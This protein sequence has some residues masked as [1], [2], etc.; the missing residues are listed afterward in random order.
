MT[1]QEERTVEAGAAAGDKPLLMETPEVP[2]AG[3][4]YRMRRLSYPD[5]ARLARMLVIGKQ[6]ARLDMLPLLAS[7]NPLTQTEAFTT[8]LMAAFGFAEQDSIAFLA[9]VLGI[10]VGEIRDPDRFPIA[11]LPAVFQ[12]IGDHPDL[13]AF[14]A[15]VQRITTLRKETGSSESATPTSPS[16]GPLIS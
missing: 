5:C 14:F 4:I 6:Q 3:R 1:E 16:S 12:A 7:G 9:S 10:Q 15:E 13:Q 2:I 11:S 8:V